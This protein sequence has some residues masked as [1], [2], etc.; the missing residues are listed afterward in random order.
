[1]NACS[2]I[3]EI[4]KNQRSRQY[5]VIG[6][7]M[8]HVCTKHPD[9]VEKVKRAMPDDEVQNKMSAF[10]KILAD[11]TRLKIATALLN[12]ELCVCDIANIV[13]MEHSAVSHQMS[14][15][16]KANVVNTR[17]DGKVIYYS[18]SDEHVEQLVSM[19]YEHV[20]E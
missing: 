12:D 2:Y 1:M 9:V 7:N 20:T 15:L 10:L 14:V 6:E 13:D 17:R 8:A 5:G 19:V 16:R 3:V 11:P 18:L 4:I